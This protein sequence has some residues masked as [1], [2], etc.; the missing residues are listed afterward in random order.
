MRRPLSRARILRAA[1]DI[2]DREGLDALTMR[3]VAAK[4]GVEA[5][6]LYHHVPNKDAI[7]EGVFDLV[8]AK[9]D[10]PEGDDVTAADWI[11]GTADAFR[12]LAQ[13]HPRAF[14]LL[15]SRPVPL[16]DAAAARPMEAGLAAF[17]RLGL[18]EAEAYAAIQAV[19]VSLL[20][21]GLMDSQLAVN[22]VPVAESRIADLPPAEFPRLHSIPA[23]DVDLAAVWDCLVDA[24]VHGLTDRRR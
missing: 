13:E 18:T 23:L 16:A 9:A 20:S 1:L 10:L 7:L 17:A 24:L 21:L 2:V 8:I 5:M 3:R 6:S 14:P 19:A 15:T 4:L 11:R 12:R 22:G